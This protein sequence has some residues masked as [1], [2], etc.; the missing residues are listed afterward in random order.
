MRAIAPGKIILSGEHAVVYGKPALVMAVNRHAEARVAGSGDS[1]VHFELTDFDENS[2]LTI[3]ALRELKERLIRNYQMFLNGELS[4]RQVLKKPCNLFEFLFI[5]FL[6]GEQLKL[7]RGVKIRLHSDIPIGSGMG[8]SAATLLSVLRVLAEYFSLDLKTKDYYRY[9]L[10]AEKL[11]HG[12]PS[13]VDPFASLYGGF[14]RFQNQKAEKLAM[15]ELPFFIVNTGSPTSTTGECVSH[16]AANFG[17]SRI[18]D[19]FEAVTEEL[20][21]VLLKSNLKDVYRCI[22]EN[23]RLLQAIGVTPSPV[24]AFIAEI[25]RA[26]GAAKVA[27]AGAVRGDNAGMV[28][29]FADTEPHDLVRRFG[30]HCMNVKGDPLGARI[31]QSIRPRQAH[32]FQ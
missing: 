12:H 22:R 19:E 8:S 13:G 1:R 6:D 14:L 9:G 27:G 31:I 21:N 18:W 4:I 10:E 30:Y 3:H 5:T 32:A 20:Q 7:D 26:G 23:S 17:E 24:Q 2:S 29:V 15:P 11:Q 16:V 25:E 28:I